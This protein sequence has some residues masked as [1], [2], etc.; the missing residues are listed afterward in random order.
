MAIP[1]PSQQQVFDR[2]VAEIVSGRYAPGARVPAERDL[3]VTYK[4]SRPTIREAL[5]R[6]EEWRL[7][8]RRRGSGI[9]VREQREWSFD[10][11]PAYLRYG[12]PAQ[13]PK[14]VA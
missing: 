13:G 8:T 6:L 1:V 10:V 11:L 3:A 14:A 7:I 2:L 9:V 5:R 4:A 12:A